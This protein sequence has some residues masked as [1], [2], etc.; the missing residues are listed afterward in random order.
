MIISTT[1]LLILK[2]NIVYSR[3]TTK[4]KSQ[5]Q[6][7]VSTVLIAQPF[8]QDERYKRSVILLIDHGPAGS[9]GIILNK[10]SNLCVNEVVSDLKL[11]LPLY[12]GGPISMESMSFIHSFS[13]LPGSAYLGK[14]LF[15]NGNFEELLRMVNDKVIRPGKIKFF[16]G[17]VT[18]SAG[19]L[20]AEIQNK[21]W[22]TSKITSHELFSASADDLWTYELLLNGNIYGLLNEFPDPGIN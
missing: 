11:G 12:F 22:W 5:V 15:L 21:Q 10:L 9:T 3:V 18:W 20:E 13:A 4:M 7:A 1:E 2:K 6:L 17:F 8:W 19:E 14:D 16:S